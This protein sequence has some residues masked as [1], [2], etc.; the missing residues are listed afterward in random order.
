MADQKNN[1]ASMAAF[2]AMNFVVKLKNA[3]SGKKHEQDNKEKQ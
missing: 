1:L 3:A 2:R